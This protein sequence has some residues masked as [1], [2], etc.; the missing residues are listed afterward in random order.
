MLQLRNAVGTLTGARIKYSAPCSGSDYRPCW[1]FEDLSL[2]NE[3][4][5]RASLRLCENAGPRSCLTLGRVNVSC[6]PPPTLDN[7][8]HATAIV[9]YLLTTHYC[10]SSIDCHT[11]SLDAYERL[12]ILALQRSN[13]IKSL[14][15]HLAGNDRDHVL[16]T[17]IPLMDQ[18]EELEC[19]ASKDCPPVLQTSLSSFLRKT[20]SLTAL[21]FPDL[22]MK[23]EQAEEFIQTLHENHTV[24]ELSLHASIISNTSLPY[25]VQFA[26]YLKKTKTLNAL[27]LVAHKKV[28]QA[29]LRWV[30]VG[31]QSNKSISSVSLVG[32]VP[33]RTN[34]LALS[35]VLKRD[36]Y[37]C[38]FTFSAPKR[39][40]ETI[41]DLEAF[42]P[43]LDYDC[44]RVALS[45]NK[46]LEDLVL[47]MRI[48]KLDQWRQFF[49]DLS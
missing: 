22:R 33:T 15:L 49:E 20:R 23:T 24:R 32:F 47:P 21:R 35:K 13:F 28:E 46:T 7:L 11:G 27:S 48:W 42:Q 29:A 40:L 8:R 5:C 44:W 16:C 4:L 39:M 14:K 10:V 9:Y 36:G 43:N 2:W 6:L 41:A 26:E 31:L 34:V 18:L 19:S 1:I 30:L 12:F 45:K 3:L 17:A 25:R 37:L 38:R